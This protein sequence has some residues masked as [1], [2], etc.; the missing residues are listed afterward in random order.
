[1]TYGGTSGLEVG[2][3]YK[4]PLGMGGTDRK[5]GGYHDDCVQFRSSTS[6]ICS[7]RVSRHVV[8]DPEKVLPPFYTGRGHR[9]QVNLYMTSET[10]CIFWVGT[11]TINC[12]KSSSINLTICYTTVISCIQVS[13]SK[14][15]V[16]FLVDSVGGW[17]TFGAL[18]GSDMKLFWLI[19]QRLS[20]VLE[21]IW[22]LKTEGVKST[23]T[24]G[25]LD[26]NAI[27]YPKL[28]FQCCIE[29]LHN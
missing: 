24:P 4:S 14:C 29:T 23:M 21:N 3:V 22:S 8:L 26:R 6:Q 16:Q 9:C 10:K 20:T 13:R 7:P 19:D 1:M 15:L 27:Q 12:V 25:S 28:C 5:E 17:L 18:K 2:E 11:R